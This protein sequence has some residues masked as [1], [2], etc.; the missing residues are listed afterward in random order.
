M[1]NISTTHRR[2]ASSEGPGDPGFREYFW[3]LCGGSEGNAIDDFV[4]MSMNLREVRELIKK[5]ITEVIET[6]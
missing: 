4:Y 2:E 5:F 6:R 3:P 1:W